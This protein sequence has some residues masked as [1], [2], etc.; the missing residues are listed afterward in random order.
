MIEYEKIGYNDI[1]LLEENIILFHEKIVSEYGRYVPE[2]ILRGYLPPEKS[3]I[4]NDDPDMYPIEV[5]LPK[6]PPLHTIDGFG[7]PAA[8][9]FFRLQEMPTKLTELVKTS[10]NY[11]DVIRK[12]DNNRR[13]YADV[14]YWIEKQWYYR[15]NGYWFFNNGVPTYI[16]G[17]HFF[18]CN[19]FHLDIGLP[20][21]NYRDRLFFIFARYC[22]TTH[23]A[24]FFHRIQIT[25]AEGNNPPDYWYFA[26]REQAEKYK[27]SHE[28]TKYEI[29]DGFWIIEYSNRTCYGFNY[30]KH[31]REGA[32]YKGA[33]IHVEIVSRMREAKGLLVSMDGGAAED[34]F[35]NKYKTPL[36]KMAFFFSPS[37][38]TNLNTQKGGIE[39]DL[40]GNMD[41]QKAIM[42]EEGLMSSM[43]PQTSGAELKSDGNKF[44]FIHGDEV[45]KGNKKAPY[46]AL[47]RH[48]VLV[49]TV[50][51]RPAIHGMIIN[52]STADDTRGDFGRNYKVL[53]QRS[54]WHQR[55]Y[56]EGTTESGLFDLFIP[57]YVNLSSTMTDKYGYPL[58]DKLTKEQQMDTGERFGAKILIE[59]KLEQK[60]GDSDAYYHEIREFPTRYRHCFL[61]STEDAQFDVLEINNRISAIDMMPSP[62]IR[63]GNFEWVKGWGSA[64]EFVDTPNGKFYISY[65]PARPNNLINVDGKLVAGNK[66]LFIA[67]CDPFRFEKTRNKRHSKGGGCVY[68][69]REITL[70]PETKTLSE[71]TT[72]RFVCTYSNSTSE[73]EYKENMLMMTIFYGCEM[74]PEMNEEM[75]Y[76]YF[77]NNKYRHLLGYTYVDGRRAE[78]PGVYTQSAS[79]AKMFKLWKMKVERNI[80]HELHVDML[81][82]LSN[83]EGLDDMKDYDLFASGAMCLYADH[84][85]K[86]GLANKV[87]DALSQSSGEDSILQWILRQQKGY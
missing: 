6:P 17:W 43:H 46:N 76:K 16:D 1:R 15:I 34:T 85:S 65:Y 3:V 26:D 32:T 68:M 31:R 56:V 87:E 7:L 55:Y 8:E 38:L 30:P 20:K 21:F 71:W 62:P 44:Q 50:A 36:R 41:K 61:A 53:C 52:T 39:F 64:V 13:E 78:M 63:K 67:G 83:V 79:K 49:K 60:Q 12:I 35:T 29:E 25:E 54:H 5:N 47:K 4:L 57:S 22:Y 2:V 73:E 66:D 69:K 33:C 48:D 42:S 59:T 28:I 23:E 24:P 81:H 40:S 86:E 77:K 37:V 51:Q 19:Y 11:Y 82:E 84:Y 27:S 10:K 74:F 18:Y 14:I 70:D 58:I 75:V 9:Q 45:G 80:R 72:D